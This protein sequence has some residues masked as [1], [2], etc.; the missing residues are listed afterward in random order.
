MENKER[1]KEE[2]LGR[3]IGVSTMWEIGEDMP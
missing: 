2:G 1:R 3:G